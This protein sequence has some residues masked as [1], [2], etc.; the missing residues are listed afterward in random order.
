MFNCLNDDKY[1]LKF[2][3]G[4]IQ[5]YCGTGY[6]RMIFD[7]ISDK[8]LVYPCTNLV[9]Y[10]LIDRALLQKY[11]V[12]LVEYFMDNIK[13]INFDGDHYK[14]PMNFYCDDKYNVLLENF[15]LNN[16][17]TGSKNANS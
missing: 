11:S 1:T 7:K 12:E 6:A 5:S 16:T 3:G 10:N 2:L 4:C 9:Y 13:I 8:T 15:V 17:A 14:L